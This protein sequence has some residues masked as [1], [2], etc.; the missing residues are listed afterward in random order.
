MPQMPLGRFRLNDRRTQLQPNPWQPVFI[1]A[2]S[3]NEIPLESGVG[4][5]LGFS[6]LKKKEV[7]NPEY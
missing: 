4:V 1:S 3:R 5:R 6:L 7:K 2:G